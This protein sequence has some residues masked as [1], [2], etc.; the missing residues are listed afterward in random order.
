ML[1]SCQNAAL[2]YD[3]RVVADG[4]RFTVSAGD[5]L[6]V[7]GEN[8]SGKTTLLHGLLGWKTP[9]TGKI[10]HAAQPQNLGI[11]YLPQQT[12]AQKD[13]PASVFEVVLSGRIGRLGFRPFYAAADKVAAQKNLKRLG[14]GRFG[15]QCFRELSGGQQRRA[16]LARALCAAQKLLILDEP[17]AGLDPAAVRDVYALLQKLNADGL[18]I[19]MVSHDLPGALSHA[20]HILHLQGRQKFFGTVKDYKAWRKRE[21]A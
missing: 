19:I 21:H 14:L 15:R 20:T 6:C 10:I 5:Y 18:T 7:L 3:G 12:A 9:C 11:G 8:G 16:L 4:L 17:L 1:L 13:F 2:A